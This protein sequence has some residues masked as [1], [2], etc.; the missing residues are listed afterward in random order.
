MVKSAGLLKRGDL[1]GA[2]ALAD[3]L[4]RRAQPLRARMTR[5]AEVYWNEHPIS[6]PPGVSN[7]SVLRSGTGK[8]QVRL[9]LGLM[10]QLPT[11]RVFTTTSSQSEKDR[12]QAIEDFDNTIWDVCQVQEGPVWIPALED[13]LLYGYSVDRLEVVPSRLSVKNGAP[14]PDG[15]DYAYSLDDPA[16]T[17]EARRSAY[18]ADR[19]A[20]VRGLG[21]P[22]AKLPLRWFHCPAPQVYFRLEDGEPVVVLEVRIRSAKSV[23]EDPLYARKLPDFRRRVARLSAQDKATALSLRVRFCVLEDNHLCTY[24]LLPEQEAGDGADWRTRGLQASL[25]GDFTGEL[26]DQYPNLLGRPGYIVT[27]AFVS[28]SV[29]PARQWRGVIDDMLDLII[30]RDS[31]MS[32]AVTRQKR[33][34]FS[35]AVIQTQ[36]QQFQGEQYDLEGDA[37]AGEPT[38]VV[39][40]AGANEATR[41]RPGETIQFLTAPAPSADE[42]GT[43]AWIDRSIDNLGT[44][45]SL[46]S[47]HQDISGFALS[48]LESLILA[49]DRVILENIRRSH[50]K[51]V[52]LLHDLLKIIKEPLSVLLVGD[53]NKREA[54]WYELKP[55]D[56]KGLEHNVQAL[57]DISRPE[58]SAQDISLYQQAVASG[59]FN[60]ERARQIYLHTEDSQRIERDRMID[61]FLDTPQIQELMLSAIARDFTEEIGR[62]Q[63]QEQGQIS[64]D[65]ARRMS[66]GLVRALQQQTLPGAPGYDALQAV[67][68]AGQQPQ[69][70][71][72]TP[73]LSPY[74]TPTPSPTS[75]NLEPS[76][77]RAGRGGRPAGLAKRPGGE[78]RS[79]P[80]LG[81]P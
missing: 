6:F 56:L 75:Q 10:S 31:L 7:E 68:Q 35:P 78:K 13:L 70:F 16:A 51:R 24:L 17:R 49:A 81:G 36:P 66:P 43:V 65:D 27:P 5:N 62:L 14:D 60:R 2:I 34:T 48:K 44:P 64:A 40:S 54:Q 71:A 63:A 1:E 76:S 55:E 15:A 4:I 30:A 69:Q 61:G 38:A 57:F 23:L 20:F 80:F 29:D 67:T 12:A 41:L 26:A 79:E 73:A 3:D 46:L 37:T 18:A 11:S 52:V 9:L 8:A 53:A 47:A 22:A 28:G 39:L 59:A 72:P 32:Y 74:N 21:G 58:N 33:F 19:A 50:T 25:A 45:D 42:L 77:K